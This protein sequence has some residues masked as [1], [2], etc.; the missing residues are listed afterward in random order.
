MQKI[1]EWTLITMIT[2]LY[3]LQVTGWG[4]KLLKKARALFGRDPVDSLN[5]PMGPEPRTGGPLQQILEMMHAAADAS[6]EIL[7]MLGSLTAKRPHLDMLPDMKEVIDRISDRLT[8]GVAIMTTA[9]RETER[10]QMVKLHNDVVDVG[11][12]QAALAAEQKQMMAHTQEAARLLKGTHGLE[13]IFQHVTGVMQAVKQ[14][15]P[16]L[17]RLM[18]GDMAE[19][20]NALQRATATEAIELPNNVCEVLVDIEDSMKTLAP[21][22]GTGDATSQQTVLLRCISAHNGDEARG[23]LGERAA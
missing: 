20:K 21:K 18:G 2:L 6:E 16:N 9:S 5:Q 7:K 17:S 19:I 1:F 12:G 3:L 10:S 23:D 14:M 15:G 8:D 13:P 4:V 11:K 22:L